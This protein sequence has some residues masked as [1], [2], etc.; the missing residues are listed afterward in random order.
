MVN[1][2]ILKEVVSVYGSVMNCSLIKNETGKYSVGRNLD[3]IEIMEV[4][5]A[6][7]EEFD[8]EFDSDELD[9]EIFASIETVCEIVSGKI[10]NE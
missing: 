8:I 4:V 10:E 3:S 9:D 1:N 7:E 2:E 5:V 6:L